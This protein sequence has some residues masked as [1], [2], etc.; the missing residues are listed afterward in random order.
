MNKEA[1]E[2]YLPVYENSVLNGVEFKIT[3]AEDI[4]TPDGTVRIKK[5]EVADTITTEK[6]NAISKPLYLGKYFVT[7]TKNHIQCILSMTVKM[8]KLQIKI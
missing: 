4:K 8:L 6:G 2:K 1:E 5:G 3:A 7:E